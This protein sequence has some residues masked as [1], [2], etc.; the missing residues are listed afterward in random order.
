MKI[1][2]LIPARGGSKGVP[3]KNMKPLGNQPLVGHTIAVGLACK[4]ISELIVSTDDEEIA[5]ISRKAGAL[6][7]FLRPAELATD[8]SPTI[9]T[10][11]HALEFYL[12][13]DRHF[14]AVCLLQPTT[15]FRSRND[16]TAAL[17]LFGKSQAD[18]LIS[19][20]EVPHIFNPHW[21][22]ETD[23]KSGF[24]RP[25]T[26]DLEFITRRQ[27]LPPA[28]YRDGAIYITRTDVLLKQRSIYGQ[29]IMAYRMQHSPDI[30]I[31]GPEDW[32]R[33]ERYLM[34]RELKGDQ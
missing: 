27:D 11:M 32:L 16:L 18:C 25:A 24:L 19:V 20:R 22:F 5:A 15:P 1:L 28:Y 8:Q 10:I 33:A 12:R 13:Q 4:A 26:G 29:N 2:G 9:D 34:S 6:V 31:D 17:T 14:D 3:R 7:P 23:R 30:N 21:V